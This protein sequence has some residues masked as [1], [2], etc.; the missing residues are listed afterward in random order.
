MYEVYAILLL[1]AGVFI[2]TVT[3]SLVATFVVT[4]KPVWRWIMRRSMSMA[5]ELGDEFE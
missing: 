5:Q 1:A 3:A 4:R 2:G